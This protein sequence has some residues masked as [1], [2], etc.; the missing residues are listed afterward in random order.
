MIYFKNSG[1]DYYP[2]FLNANIGYTFIH[3][4]ILL[5]MKSYANLFD[6]II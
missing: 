2:E 6:K 4:L 1:R 5:N 3:F